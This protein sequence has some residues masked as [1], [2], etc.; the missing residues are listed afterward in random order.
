MLPKLFFDKYGHIVQNKL[1]GYD[2]GDSFSFNGQYLVAMYWQYKVGLISEKELSALKNWYIARTKSLYKGYGVFS[3][4][5]HYK[6]WSTRWNRMSRDQLKSNIYAMAI[7]GMW[8]YLLITF[9]FLILRLG[10]TTNIFKNSLPVEEES[11][12]NIKLPD[13]CGPDILAMFGRA[14]SKE[15]YA[16]SIL[17]YPIILLGDVQTLINAYLKANKKDPTD[18]N[19]ANF[20]TLLLQAKETR[21]T[22]ISELAS[23]YYANNRG[24]AALGKQEKRFTSFGPQSALDYFFS[25]RHSYQMEPPLHEEYRPFLE[26]TLK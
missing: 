23:K 8:K 12:K 19:E 7:A 21:P 18:A 14:L 4:H 1:Q 16:I 17:F 25:G 15:L 22:I 11:I 20:I 24:L 9:L 6:E 10:F 26:N 3:R 5:S 2:G 13:L